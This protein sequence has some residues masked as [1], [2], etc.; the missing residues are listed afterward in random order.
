MPIA[1]NLA[2]NYVPALPEI[3]LIVSACAVLLVDLF[4]PDPRRHISYWLTLLGIGATAFVTLR[5]FHNTPV[6]TFSTMFVAAAFGDVSHF[7]HCIPTLLWLVAPRSC[8]A[9]GWVVSRTV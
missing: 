8:C 3:V 9:R 6:P 2:F 5:L 1:A 4:V 7:M